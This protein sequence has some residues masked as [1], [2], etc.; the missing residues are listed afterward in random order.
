MKNGEAI[1]NIIEMNPSNTD[2]EIRHNTE[3]KEGKPFEVYLDIYSY[4]AEGVKDKI[5]KS[6]ILES[7][8]TLEE[9]AELVNILC[10]EDDRITQEEIQREKKEIE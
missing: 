7:F 10:E 3:N 8:K 2:L 1:L 6:F 5:F 4:E 9:A